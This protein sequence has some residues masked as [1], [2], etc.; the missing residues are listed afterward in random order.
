M[1]ALRLIT[2]L[3][4][5]DDQTIEQILDKYPLSEI[6]KMKEM[7]FKRLKKDSRR[8]Y[9]VDIACHPFDALPKVALNFIS[10]YRGTIY[11][12]EDPILILMITLFKKRIIYQKVSTYDLLP[13]QYLVTKCDEGG[14]WFEIFSDDN[15]SEV[16]FNHVIGSDYYGAPERPPT[17]F[18]DLTEF[19]IK[20]KWKMSLERA[21]EKLPLSGPYR[22]YD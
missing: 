11:N 7:L 1:E 3:P 10:K 16:N 19:A 21:A 12:H 4:N 15:S 20:N 18:K 17:L 5:M 14:P 8:I 9:I 13:H 2:V 6:Y 22:L